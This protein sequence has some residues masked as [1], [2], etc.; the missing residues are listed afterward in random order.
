MT[1]CNVL[2][3]SE[4]ASKSTSS[5]LIADITSPFCSELLVDE[6]RRRVGSL[7]S[8]DSQSK[9]I[10]IIFEDERGDGRYICSTV[11]VVLEGR[12]EALQIFL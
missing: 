10:G 5:G 9:F 6:S 2:N 3:L 7:A 12:K 11:D 1:V 4:N 8:V